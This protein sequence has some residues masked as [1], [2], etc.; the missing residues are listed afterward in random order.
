MKDL[1]LNTRAK[2]YNLPQI[3]VT[4]PTFGLENIEGKPAIS[5]NM[6]F[7]YS[8]SF[9]L[10]QEACGKRGLDRHV[11]PKWSSKS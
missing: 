1:K 9:I 10:W 6:T 4:W 3:A 11:Y 5:S 8:L 7:A 2:E